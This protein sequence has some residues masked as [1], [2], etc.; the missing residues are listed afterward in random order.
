MNVSLRNDAIVQPTEQALRFRTPQHDPFEVG[1]Y[2]ACQCVAICFALALHHW[3]LA[4]SLAPGATLT[5]AILAA[6]TAV[7]G[8]IAV[9]FE[10]RLLAMR[11]HW[12]ES[13]LPA[14]AIGFL[15]GLA[16]LWAVATRADIAYVTFGMVAV[17]LLMTAVRAGPR[18]AVVPMLAGVAIGYWAFLLS[19][20]DGYKTPWIE[21]AILSGTVHVDLL[22]HAAIANMLGGYGV[23]SLGVDGLAT[24]PYHFGSH[25]LMMVLYG[26]LGIDPLQFYS[27]VFPLIFSPL[28][29]CVMFLFAVAFKGFLTRVEG[30]ESSPGNSPAWYWAVASICFIGVIAAPTRRELGVWENAF[31]SE[32]FGVALLVAYL[33]GIWLFDQLG[34]QKRLRI[35]W[36]GGLLLALYLWV[37]CL[38]KISVGLVIGAVFGYALLRSRESI[39]RKLLGCLAI[40]LPLGYGLWLTRANTNGDQAAASLLE[41]IKP[42]AFLR[43]SVGPDLY[44]FSFLAFFGP[45]IIFVLYRLLFPRQNRTSGLR[46]RLK[47]RTLL[48]VE[49]AV[50]ITVTSVLPG[51]VLE[52]PQGSTNFFAEVSYWWMQPLMAI[53]VS[54]VLT[55]FTAASRQPDE[56]SQRNRSEIV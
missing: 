48:D 36:W 6:A 19:F 27:V 7:V 3:V 21:Q 52:V 47:N 49:L 17:R 23:G 15:A 53:V 56:D 29:V 46:L 12:F 34:G 5:T 33:G 44:V 54:R 26:L 51:I 8:T 41:S 24:F 37:L 4:P 16:L 18:A 25:R 45:V 10:V 22:F 28:F 42:F 38:L 32:S 13:P 55:R 40:A 35:T 14:L 20:V 31:H 9:T 39:Y 11:R 1:G 30:N 2:L 50:V 43:D